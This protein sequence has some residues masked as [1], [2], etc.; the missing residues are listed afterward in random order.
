MTLSDLGEKF[1]QPAQGIA[2]GLLTQIPPSTGKYPLNSI[3]LITLCSNTA[4]RRPVA[5][6][7]RK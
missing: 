1:R 6:A 4:C 3:A 7:V 2:K 5:S